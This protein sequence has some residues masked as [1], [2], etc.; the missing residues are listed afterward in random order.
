MKVFGRNNTGSIVITLIGF[1]VIVL[2]YGVWN[3]HNQFVQPNNYAQISKPYNPSRNFTIIINAWSSTFGAQSPIDL[4]VT[5]RPDTDSLIEYFQ[6]GK[7]FAAEHSGIG[8]PKEY[9]LLF[10][11]TDCT[12]HPLILTESDKYKSTDTCGIILPLNVADEKLYQYKGHATFTFPV[13]GAYGIY[14][15]D[16]LPKTSIKFTEYKG[17]KIASLDATLN[18]R[19][20]KLITILT[21]VGVYFGGVA[22]YRQR[23]DD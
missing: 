3:W 19:N 15:D 22:V 12:K 10:E 16:T 1:G 8:L 14:L 2:C 4:Y 18:E 5:L 11:G 7:T 13:E 21:I 23:R 17:I 6:A 9:F 20:N